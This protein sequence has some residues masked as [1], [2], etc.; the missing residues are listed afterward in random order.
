[1]EEATKFC[2]QFGEEY[3][4]ISELPRGVP[5]ASF[6]CFLKPRGSSGTASRRSIRPLAHEFRD[7]GRSDPGPLDVDFVMTVHYYRV[8]ARVGPELS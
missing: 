3:T 1:M 5:D 7:F 4:C 6:P 8:A 2:K